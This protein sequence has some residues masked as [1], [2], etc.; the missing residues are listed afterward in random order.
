MS[1]TEIE[2]P[3]ERQRADGGRWGCRRGGHQPPPRCQLLS[4]LDAPRVAYDKTMMHRSFVFAW[5]LCLASTLPAVAAADEGEATPEPEAVTAITAPPTRIHFD[6]DKGGSL[7]LWQDGAWATKC[8][9][10]CT[11]D[12]PGSY[13][14]VV[15]V[16]GGGKKVWVRFDGRGGELLSLRYEDRGRTKAALLAG[17]IVGIA[18]GLLFLVAATVT[19]LQHG[20]ID[21]PP[22]GLSEEDREG[23]A[24]KSRE[25]TVG[26]V[27]LLGGILAGIGSAATT[28][29]R[30]TQDRRP[31]LVSPGRRPAWWRTATAVAAHAPAVPVLSLSF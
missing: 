29:H 3:D 16:R 1:A 7:R 27:L 4:L 20:E 8:S 9:A 23:Q 13:A 22:G 21:P 15:E 26:A 31:S 2:E 12:V 5:A 19:G 11:F 24:T 14:G 10:S 17:S 6:A 28:R 18:G 25:Q 30:I